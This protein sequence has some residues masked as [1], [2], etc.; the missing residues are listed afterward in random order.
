MPTPAEILAQ[1][2][3]PAEW[4]DWVPTFSGRGYRPWADEPGEVDPDDVAY[5]L[6][7]T[8]R[9]GGQ[10]R[11]AITVAEHSVLATLIV[12]TLWPGHERLEK[13]A[14]MHDAAEAYLHDI[15]SPLRR[16][17]KVQING[18]LISWSASDLLVT[19]NVCRQFGIIE[20]DLTAPEITAADI[21]AA[22][23]EKRDCRNLAGDWGLPEIPEAI[24]HLKMNFWPP[25]E[26][27]FQFMLAGGRLG[28]WPAP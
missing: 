21:L 10:S 11:P 13:A 6:A 2:S 9:Y 19:E 23:F 20:M 17:V 15:Q 16:R 14:L 27:R 5:G 22:C 8:F 1:M 12:K 25:A 4:H 24:A 26:A 18:E 3:R 28:L 7:H